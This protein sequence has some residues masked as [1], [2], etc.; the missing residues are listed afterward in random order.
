MWLK[1]QPLTVS[2][3]VGLLSR[4]LY[5]TPPCGAYLLKKLKKKKAGP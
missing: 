5:Y 2:G 4:K 3:L 1:V